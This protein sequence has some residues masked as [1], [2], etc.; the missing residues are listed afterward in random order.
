MV[1]PDA[2]LPFGKGHS[3][4]S[5]V[6]V[7]PWVLLFA[8]CFLAFHFTRR[9]YVSQENGES[10]ILF[11]TLIIFAGIPFHISCLSLCVSSSCWVGGVGKSR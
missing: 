4:F 2:T 11:S 6:G 5:L 1:L 7:R 3:G 10:F 8:F 9:V